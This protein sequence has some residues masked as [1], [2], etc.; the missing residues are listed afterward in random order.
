MQRTDQSSQR[1]RNEEAAHRLMIRSS[2][3]KRFSK[4]AESTVADRKDGRTHLN[5]TMVTV[6]EA[7]LFPTSFAPVSRLDQTVENPGMI[8]QTHHHSKGN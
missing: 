8:K 4:E 3:H 7:T 2:D 1:S 6:S 5:L